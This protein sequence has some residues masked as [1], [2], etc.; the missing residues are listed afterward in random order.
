MIQE[1]ES[2]GRAAWLARPEQAARGAVVVCHGG[3]GLAPHEREVIERLA[4]LGYV[5]VAPDLFG[6]RPA[7]RAGWM[8]MIQALVGEPTELRRRVLAA[9]SLL[10]HVA[11]DAED[12]ARIAVIGHCFGGTAALEAAR[13]GADLACAVAFHGGLATAAPAERIAARVLAC[14]GAADPF[15]P[16]EQ[17]AAFEDE[18]T[19]AGASWQLHVYGGAQH[20]FTVRGI[21]RPGCAYD[22][23]ADAASWQAAIA[24]LDET[25]RA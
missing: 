9:V 2:D 7:D 21:D 11:R 16:R 6:E 10:R 17:R 12:E 4:A 19:A 22:E 8:A 3:G 25:I 23:R 18:M 13:S 24:L 14:C 1:I 15:C 5:A 20:G